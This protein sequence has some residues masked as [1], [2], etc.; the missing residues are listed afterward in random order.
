MKFSSNVLR[1]AFAIPI[2]A[3]L[4]LCGPVPG[5]AADNA[6]ETEPHNRLTPEEIAAGWIILFDG[7]TMFGWK[8]NNDVN[9]RIA[10]GGVQ[11]DTG[12]PGLL[13]T[14]TEFADFELRCDFRLSKG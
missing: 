7:R 2:L 6:G 11:A 1:R 3:V 14:T 5:W 13:V 8:A 4:A 9:W 10:S 12:E